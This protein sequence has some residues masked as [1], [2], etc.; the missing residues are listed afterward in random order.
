MPETAHAERLL[1]SVS[2][3]C[4]QLNLSRSS[5]YR[6]VRAGSLRPRKIGRKTLFLAADVVAFASGEALQ[7]K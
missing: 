4:S 6:Q 2:E 5:L 1:V 7:A 3:A